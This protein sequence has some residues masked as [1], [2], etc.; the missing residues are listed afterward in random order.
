M[1]VIIQDLSDSYISPLQ[2]MQSNK[3]HHL[4]ATLFHVDL[5]LCYLEMKILPFLFLSLT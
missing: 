4:G 2:Q 1:G 3:M 5:V